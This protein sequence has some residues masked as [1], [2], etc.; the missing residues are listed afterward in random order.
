MTYNY[1]VK[2]ENL[3]PVHFTQGFFFLGTIMNHFTYNTI[4][5]YRFCQ[6]TAQNPIDINLWGA[7]E[8]KLFIYDFAHEFYYRFREIIMIFEIL[9]SMFSYMILI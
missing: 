9:K 4:V 5:D 7:L 1:S 2:V 8:N 3:P 6:I